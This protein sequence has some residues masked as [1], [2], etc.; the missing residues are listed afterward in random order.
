MIG[1]GSGILQDLMI[2]SRDHE[3][4]WYARVSYC[5]S[6]SSSSKSGTGYFKITATPVTWST[7]F[8][9]SC[10]LE[11]TL[12]S[13]P[14]DLTKSLNSMYCC[15]LEISSERN[16]ESV[17]NKFFTAPI[18]TAFLHSCGPYHAVQS[19]SFNLLKNSSKMRTSLA[20]LVS[21]SF[22][23]TSSFLSTSS[24]P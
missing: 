22:F 19:S 2:W 9:D 4:I 16:K 24:N 10:K 1:L 18:S 3:D 15:L 17:I 21:E 7:C 14:V 8:P 5:S 6:S 23:C 13:P 20:N 11:N 12:T